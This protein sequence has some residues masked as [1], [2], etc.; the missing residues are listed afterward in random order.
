MLQWDTNVSGHVLKHPA[1]T[2]Y[3]I[4]INIIC[5]CSGFEDHKT[6]NITTGTKH[7]IFA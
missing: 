4:V 3:I 5:V 1:N 2:T 6:P 7:I